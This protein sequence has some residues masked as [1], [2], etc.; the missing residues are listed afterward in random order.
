MNQ[1]FGKTALLAGA[2]A[3][4]GL[5]WTPQAMA[6]SAVKSVQSVQ[7]DRKVTGT[8]VDAMGPVIGASILEKGTSNG[9]VT[10]LDGNYSLSVKP[11]ATL[12]IS[13]IGYKTQE[14]KVG[15]NT[16]IDVTLEEDNTSLEEVV[17]VGYGVQKKK[18]VTGA[19]V[20]VKGEDIAK[21]NTTNALTAMQ[22]STPGVQITQASAQPGQGFK[23][24]I[25]GVGTM[26]T[27]SP[28]LIIDGISS[29][30]ADDGLN[31]L[32]PADI[33][34]IDVLKDAA[35]AAIYG[36]RAANGVILVTTKQGKVG[37]IQASYDGY[38]GWSNPAR[39][40]ATLNAKEY[41]QIINEMNF[42]T[43][44]NAVKWNS[45]VPQSV[46]DKVNAGWEGTDWFEIYRNKNAM[47]FNHS[48][49]LTGGSE[50]SKFAM[51]LNYTSNNGTFGG[52]KAPQYKRY[53]AR[54]NSEHVLLKGDKHDVIT[55]GENISFWYNTRSGLSEGNGYW[56]SI[57]PVYIASPLVM[58]Y[59][60]DGSLNSY[61]Q[62]STGY[63]GQ[64]WSNPLQGLRAGQF[65]STQKNRD[66]GVGA[67]FFWIIE[68]I[69][70]LRYRGSF[71]TGFSS[72][73]DR[74][75]GRPFSMNQSASSGAYS[76]SLSSSDGGSFSV[77]NTLTYVLPVLAKNA[78]DVMIGQSF[79]KTQWGQSLSVGTQALEGEEKSMVHQGIYAW[80]SNFSASQISSFSGAPWGDSSLASFFGRINW[81]YDEKYMATF[82]MRADGSS[83]FARGHRWGYFPSVSAGWVVTGEKF[84][85]STRSWLDYFKIRASWGQNGNCAIPNF[86]YLAT[87]SYSPTDYADYAY[88]FGSSMAQTLSQTSYAPGAFADIIPNEDITWETSEQ[89]NIGFDARFLN[90]KLGLNF[91]WYK[92]TTKDW[93]ILAPA[94]LVLGTNAPYI[95]GGDIENKGIEV[96]LS[97]NDQIG[98]DFR[99]RAN[100][101]FATN[102]NEV[103]RIA[104]EQGI[105]NGQE[106]A[107][108]QNSSYAS[109]V[110]VGHPIA[111]FY[112]MDYEGIWQNQA[113]IDAARAAGKAVRADAQ[114]GD[115]IWTDYDGDGV[116][117]Y[118][119]D[120]HEIG[121]PHPDFTL[122]VTLGFDWKG[123]DFSVTGSGQF[124]M[125]VMQYFRTAQLAN[126][127]DNYTQDI[128]DRW[129][130]E[131]TSNTQPRLVL[132][133]DNNQWVSTRYM[134]DADF[135]RIQNITLGYDFN[136]IWKSSPF[137]Q[138]RLYVQAQNL[139][140]F[141]GYTGVD[142]E[143]GSSGGKD[144]WAR[145]IDVGLYPTSRTYLVGVNIK[146]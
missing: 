107:L 90:G 101:N 88:K 122:G 7:Q 46:I 25:R 96:A 117:N 22:A 21:L 8:V 51:G 64:M 39:R 77:D 12:V 34:S 80:P 93:L 61:S 48:F 129:H 136:K 116:I 76:V 127:Y 52:D 108:F 10:D 100:V 42:N 144:S 68:P 120:R 109:R 59:G 84:M 58:P 102:K 55:I 97:W 82:T 29:G 145:G 26:G 45:I 78:I 37:K 123:L 31:G 83:N 60:E 4:A 73:T 86:Q 130:G 15:N 67:T 113:Q 14:I 119:L 47:Q 99:Y 135:F 137:Q 106:H 112:G 89:L 50:R 63:S 103:T 9:T 13:Y 71:N 27:S 36:A 95:N 133:G 79:E 57:Q 134:Q 110:Q 54:I 85:E 104:N 30:T 1:N 92:K 81:N 65:N 132:A 115:M 33:E 74:S 87:I 126:P 49:S 124:G 5:F 41:M 16:R 28:L 38:V 53:G 56:N 111:Y 125:Q 69:K 72:H 18:L 91:D 24:N 75:Y 98:S 3:I 23:V 20:Q 40:P 2:C 141:T 70:G 118:D 35:S 114:P 11:G 146:F 143:I 43:T 62:N 105:I 32:N 138:L 44:G 121:N 66:F 142:P 139:Y 19:T 94:P 128:F 6:D 140:T 131:G 17:V